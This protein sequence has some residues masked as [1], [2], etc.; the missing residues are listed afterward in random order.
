MTT[1]KALVILFFAVAAGMLSAVEYPNYARGCATRRSSIEHPNYES[2]FAVD[3]IASTRWSSR[4]SDDEWLTV[5]LGRVRRIGRIVLNWETSAPLRYVVQLS[6]DD[7]H[8]TNVFEQTEGTQGAFD[9][10]DIQ[11]QEARFIRIDCRERT[12][13][14]GFSLYEI[15]VY[16]PVE[17]PAYRCKA[18]AGASLMPEGAPEFTTDGSS[19]TAWRAPGDRE[20]WIQ[21]NLGRVRRISRLEIDWG[22]GSPKSFT[23]QL[24]EDGKR[25]SEAYSVA[26]SP[27][28]TKETIRLTVPLRARYIKLNLKEAAGEDG[29]MIREFDALP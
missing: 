24:S 3:G 6:T 7:E 13:S 19:R 12:T 4:R 8:Y 29:Y 25:F 14:Y 16:P 2:D 17:S 10:V 20:Q 28:R 1:G 11:P 27:P 26:D 9:I 22:Q 15:E 21:F 5:D 23:V 18:W